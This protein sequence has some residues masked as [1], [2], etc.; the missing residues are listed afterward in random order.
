MCP[1][2]LPG[3]QPLGCKGSW[4]RGGGVPSTKA[5]RSH[6]ANAGY[7]EE[8]MGEE[9]QKWEGGSNFSIHQAFLVPYLPKTC[10]PLTCHFFLT[11]LSGEICA[12]NQTVSVCD[13]FFM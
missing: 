3:P 1:V 11:G 8:D 4:L 6:E 13:I 12:I 10:N 5:T 9:R 2:P 7:S